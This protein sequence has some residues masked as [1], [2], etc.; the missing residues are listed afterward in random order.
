V[1]ISASKKAP[2]TSPE[3]VPST[4]PENNTD[5]QEPK[6]LDPSC[7]GFLFTRVTDRTQTRR[8]Q[9][10]EKITKDSVSKLRKI[11]DPK[12]NR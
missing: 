8:D 5:R 10:L 7:F 4:S 12:P 2:S 6:K 1:S 11:F 3:I 9:I